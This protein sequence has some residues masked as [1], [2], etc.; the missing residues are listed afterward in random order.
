MG[1]SKN[2]G[3]ALLEEMLNYKEMVEREMTK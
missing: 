2:T 1:R 3:T